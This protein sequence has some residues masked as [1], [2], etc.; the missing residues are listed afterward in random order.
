MISDALDKIDLN[1]GND[2]VLLKISRVC[3]LH[4]IEGGVLNL[5]D[6][7]ISSVKAAIGKA[8]TA[9]DVIEALKVA[10]GEVLKSTSMD[11]ETFFKPMMDSSHQ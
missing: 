3:A 10:F 7:D 8:K 4:Y 11:R 6:Q 1:E 9:D 5:N 2:I